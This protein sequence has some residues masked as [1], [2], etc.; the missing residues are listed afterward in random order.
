MKHVTWR[1][2][3]RL[4]PGLPDSAS[5][6]G[7][8]YL[9]TTKSALVKVGTS[10]APHRR[11][12]VM[13]G[14]A[15]RR[16]FEMAQGFDP[17]HARVQVV[18]DNCG[19]L[20]ERALHTALASELVGGEWYSGA[21]ISRIVGSLSAI[22]TSDHG[23]VLSQGQ[24]LLKRHCDKRGAQKELARLLGVSEPNVSCWR[25]GKAKP[26]TVFR[27]ALERATGIP[28]MAWDEPVGAAA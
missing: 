24:F 18:V 4:I 13:N 15:T 9:A 11:V 23:E 27:L 10:R 7:Y 8:V 1:D 5:E 22:A 6:H 3:Q 26:T 16:A 14:P 12:S 25:S 17:G 21:T 28:L 19:K 20:R 2:V